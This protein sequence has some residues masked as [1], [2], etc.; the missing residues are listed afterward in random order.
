L[1][2]MADRCSEL[3]RSLD[4]LGT[5][6]TSLAAAEFKDALTGRDPPGFDD[7][8]SGIR[9]IS[10]SL[11][12]ELKLVTLLTLEPREQYYFLPREPLFGAD[13]EAGFA[14]GGAFDLD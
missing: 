1:K 3:Q 12:R 14:G 10:T 2:T 7:L 11:R 8:E 9:D 4:V 13:Y 6:V 5:P